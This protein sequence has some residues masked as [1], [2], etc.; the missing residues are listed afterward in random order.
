MVTNLGYK[1][2]SSRSNRMRA[3]KAAANISL[4]IFTEDDFRLIVRSEV[5]EAIQ[6]VLVKQLPQL[7]SRNE[8]KDTRYLTRRQVAKYLGIGLSTVDYYA[9][10][11]KLKKI[12]IKGSP[13]F[14]KE[15]IDKSISTIKKYMRAA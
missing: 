7:Q 10:C 12:F 6:E 2:G 9:R 13:R 15:E 8:F 14:D 5:R 1:G 11:G 3:D 4:M